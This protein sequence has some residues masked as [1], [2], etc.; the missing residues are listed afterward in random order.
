MKKVGRIPDGG[1]WRFRGRD[2]SLHA[3]TAL[4]S[5]IIFVVDNCTDATAVVASRTGAEVIATSGNAHKKA[6]ALNQ[7]SWLPAAH[8]AYLV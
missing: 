6:G 1:G 7:S 2:T 3:Q 4:P 8:S 5:R